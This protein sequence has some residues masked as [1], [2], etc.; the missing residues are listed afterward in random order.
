METLKINTFDE[1]IYFSAR[2][3]GRPFKGIRFFLESI[4]IYLTTSEII[5]LDNIDIILFLFI[6]HSHT[7]N[8]SP[9][10]SHFA[11]ILDLSSICS[12]PLFS[13]LKLHL[14]PSHQFQFPKI[15]IARSSPANTFEV[16]KVYV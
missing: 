10:S 14:E 5:S 8:C 2:H 12:Q 3:F 16:S 6:M 9:Q 11:L 4:E 15:L 13:Y 7:I 1:N